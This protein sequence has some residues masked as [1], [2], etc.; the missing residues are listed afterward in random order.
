MSENKKIL[1]LTAQ[2]GSEIRLEFHSESTDPDSFNIITEAEAAENGVVAFQLKEECSYEYGLPDGLQLKG[3]PR[4]VRP[5][6]INSSSGRFTP[7][8]FVGTLE[9]DVIDKT[10]SNKKSE[11]VLEIC[12]AKIG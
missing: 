6:K 9:L 8:I 7:G 2:D 11:A 3:D 1:S 12:S 10:T 5:S 4:V